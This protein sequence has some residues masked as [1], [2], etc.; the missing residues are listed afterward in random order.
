MAITGEQ[1]LSGG[2]RQASEKQIHLY[3]LEK[4]GTTY[5][6][7]GSNHSVS[8][9]EL[10]KAALDCIE[11]VFSQSPVFVCEGLHRDITQARLLQYGYLRDPKDKSPYWIEQLTT[12]ESDVVNSLLDTIKV[13]YKLTFDNRDIQIGAIPLFIVGDIFDKGIDSE[14]QRK[15]RQK[16]NF[17]P[18]DH[19]DE[20]AECVQLFEREDTI[21]TVEELK[22]YLESYF[23]NPEHQAL[24]KASKLQ[25]LSGEPVW[26]A[27]DDV[28]D[29]TEQNKAW[30]NYIRQ[31]RLNKGTTAIVVGAAHL[32]GGYG[33]LSLYQKAGFAL[34]RMNV[35][36]GEFKPVQTQDLLYL[37]NR[38]IQ[39]T[40]GNLSRNAEEVKL[41]TDKA[42]APSTGAPV[43]PS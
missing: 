32:Y 38:P 41:A 11:Q 19:E 28:P 21:H 4:A 5:Y 26:V 25:Y 24:L 13:R 16:N 37:Y 33:L 12:K 1:A 36:E 8:L 29:I 18:L 15:H 3:K 14:I 22:P 35:A 10:S 39:A 31:M 43:K 6:L 7:F 30:F 9:N 42:V 27:E 2:T 40:Q 17:M 23:F 20:D 34:T